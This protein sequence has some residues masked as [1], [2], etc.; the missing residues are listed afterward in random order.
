MIFFTKKGSAL[1]Q[2][3]VLGS[4]IASLSVLLLRYTVTRSA[5]VLKTKK[6]LQTE[7]IAESCANTYMAFLAARELTGL[8]TLGIDTSSNE[9]F[10]CPI[11]KGVF[12]EGTDCSNDKCIKMQVHWTANPKGIGVAEIV[13]DT[14]KLG[15]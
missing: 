7:P 9:T 14:T 11:V 2:V 13:I 5:N 8:P 15:N 4:I 12:G 6:V 3:L 10:H 1:M